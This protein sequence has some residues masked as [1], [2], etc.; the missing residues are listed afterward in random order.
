MHEWDRV[1]E[2]IYEAKLEEV[3]GTKAAYHPYSS[4]FLLGEIVRRVD[5]RPFAKYVRDEIFLPLQMPNCYLG[6][7][8]DVYDRYHA[9]GRFCELRTMT[10]KARRGLHGSVSSRCVI[11]R[12]V[13]SGHRPTRVVGH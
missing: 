13:P 10:P 6:M 8:R 5:G 12:H 7:E 4:W 9:S 2:T 11:P 3:P 1:L